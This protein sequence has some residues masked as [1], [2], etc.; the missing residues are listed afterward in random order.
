[1]SESEANEHYGSDCSQFTGWTLDESYIPTSRLRILPLIKK[2]F[3]LLYQTTQKGQYFG[4]HTFSQEVMNSLTT[5]LLL[6]GLGYTV[7][8]GKVIVHVDGH[9]PDFWMASFAIYASLIYMTNISLLVR[10]DQITWTLM[11]YIFFLSL[12]PF[13]IMSFLFDLVFPGPNAQQRILFNIGVTYQYYLLFII[14]GVAVFM[15]EVCKKLYKV[16]WKPSIADYFRHLVK[17][18]KADDPKYFT[19][20]IFDT[21]KEADEPI[22]KKST[23]KKTQANASTTNLVGTVIGEAPA[24]AANA[25]G[26]GNQGAALEKIQ[27][28]SDYSESSI[29]D[30]EKH[31]SNNSTTLRNGSMTND[32]SNRSMLSLNS[33][34]PTQLT[35]K[36]QI[37]ATSDRELLNEKEPGEGRFSKEPFEHNNEQTQQDE[38]RSHLLR[39]SDPIKHEKSSDD[40]RDFEENCKP[41]P[42]H[43]LAPALPF[44]PEQPHEEFHEEESAVKVNNY[45]ST[46]NPEP[47]AGPLSPRRK[48]ADVV[49]ELEKSLSIEEARMN[50]D[51]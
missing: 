25:N 29:Q 44:Q 36:P 1:M 37:I 46:P 34:V 40:S 23:K 41:N 33:N 19:K 30:I 39:V 22:Q 28:D 51:H 5:A 12:G 3:H 15:I 10:V 32:S 42:V 17:T 13:F 7:Y 38:D 45:F 11:G 49:P 16:T 14:L 50:G 21:F 9:T 4:W 48:D 20:E 24:R 2:H 35:V 47:K 26:S 31:S 18:G 43:E 27:S 6:W 8:S